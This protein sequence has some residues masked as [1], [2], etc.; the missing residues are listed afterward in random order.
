MLNAAQSP[1][2]TAVMTRTN[3]LNDVGIFSIAFAT[4]NLMLFL[5]QYGLRRY[6]SSDVNEDYSFAEYYGIRIITCGIMVLACFLYCVY[7]KI[8]K[9]YDTTKFMAVFIICMGKVIQ[10]FSDVYH[11]RMQQMGRLDVATK[12]SAFRYIGEMLAFCVGLVI[13]RNL[14]ISA[15]M[16]LTASVVIYILGSRN[17]AIDY[18]KRSPSFVPGRMKQLFAEGFPLFISL[19][20]NM[21]LTNAPKEAIDLY[22]TEE[23]QAVYNLIFMPAFVVQL[24]AHFIFNP[25]ITTYAEVWQRGDVEKLKK[26]IY[27]QLLVISVLIVSGLLVAATIGIPVLSLVFG[28]DLYDLKKEL[29]IVMLGGGMLAYSV[30]F[31]TVI[32]IVRLHR[33]LIISYGVAAIAAFALSGLFVRNYGI[34]GA[35]TLYAVIMAI[36]ALI[37]AVMLF[38]FLKKQQGK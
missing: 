16:Y 30:F 23:I 33:T 34:T 12:C 6:Q 9:D 14:L 2:I 8:F 3:G 31:N 35:T 24:V 20:L 7:G 5:G 36:L 32:T 26:L 37:L 22:L 15:C 17:A 21:Y 4:A 28:V 18:C 11:G 38:S 27:R 25:I 29:C 10:A 19:F 13:T 1:I